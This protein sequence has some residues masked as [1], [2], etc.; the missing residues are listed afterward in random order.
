[1]ACEG[2]S[3]WLRTAIPRISDIYF[4]W[5]FLVK[6]SLKRLSYDCTSRSIYHRHSKEKERNG[7]ATMNAGKIARDL[8]EA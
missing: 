7:G 6:H 5:L 8:R 1:M 3:D 4:Y 2:V